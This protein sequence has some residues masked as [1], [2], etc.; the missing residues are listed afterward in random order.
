MLIKIVLTQKEADKALAK[1]V[2]EK[3]NLK[4][5]MIKIEIEHHDPKFSISDFEKITSRKILMSS[6]NNYITNN[7]SLDNW[8]QYNLNYQAKYA[9]LNNNDTYTTWFRTSDAQEKCYNRSMT[10][11][12]AI[13]FV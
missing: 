12:E 1:F 10:K 3:F 6:N 7:S 2:S 11:Q 8:A 4:Q 13:K 5:E 9:T